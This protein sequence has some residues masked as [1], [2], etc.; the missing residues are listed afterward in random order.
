MVRNPKLPKDLKEN[1]DP[2]KTYTFSL[3]QTKADYLI[4]LGKDAGVTQSKIMDE[5]IAFYLEAIQ[6][7][8][9]KQ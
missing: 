6:T 9:T 1:K 4:K 3:D 5:V 8:K 2:R 7:Q